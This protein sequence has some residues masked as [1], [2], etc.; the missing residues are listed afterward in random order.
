MLTEVDFI[1]HRFIWGLVFLLPLLACISLIVG[2]SG[3]RLDVFYQGITLQDLDSSQIIYD[4]RMP[5]LIL[6]LLTGVTLALSGF[7]M[8]TVSQNRLASPSMLGLVDGALLGVVIAKSL[9]FQS[10]WQLSLFSILGAFLT[11]G[12]VFL[13]ASFIRG[14]FIKTRLILLG[15]IL[16]NLL[17]SLANIIAYKSSIF[18]QSSLYFLGT[19]ANTSW[20]QVIL[21]LGV[22]LICLPLLLYLLPQLEGFFLDEELLQGMGKPVRQIKTLTFLL[23]AL[24]SAVTISIV[25]KISFLGLIVPNIVYLFKARKLKQQFLLTCLLG[26]NLILLA[27]IGSKLIRYPYETPLSFVVSLLGLPFFFWIIKHRGGQND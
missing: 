1:K 18:Q 14:G 25:G 19:T 11:M 3:I 9:D 8:Q 17:N 10:S 6:T 22:V 21:L 2:S 7:L 5:R 23:A 27:D 4:I 15:I 26:M 16:G 20:S 24:L 12:L 13:I